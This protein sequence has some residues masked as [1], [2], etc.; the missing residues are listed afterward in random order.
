M[1]C[2]LL[3]GFTISTDFF[4]VNLKRLRS[5][6]WVSFKSNVFIDMYGLLDFEVTEFKCCMIHNQHNIDMLKWKQQM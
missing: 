1:V 6:I 4:G 2:L 3:S 5:S